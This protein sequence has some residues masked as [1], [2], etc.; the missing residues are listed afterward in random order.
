MQ[1]SNRG[2]SPVCL[3]AAPTA[4]VATYNAHHA[5]P[6]T[7]RKGVRFYQRLKDKLAAADT[8]RPVAA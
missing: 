2:C 1:G 3:S 5:R 6:F 7:W 4:F 8:T